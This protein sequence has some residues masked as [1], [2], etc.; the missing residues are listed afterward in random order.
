MSRDQEQKIG[1]VRIRTDV[2][3]QYAATEAMECFGVV[4]MGAISLR[5]GFARILKNERITRGVDVTVKDGTVSIDFHI[6]VAYGVNIK[7]VADNLM[8]NVIYKIESFTG[9]T[10]R[11]VNVF[12]EGVRLVD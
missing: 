9:L 11:E 4:G 7:T 6:I 5:D 8:E 10:V 3:K 1:T 12:V 2:V